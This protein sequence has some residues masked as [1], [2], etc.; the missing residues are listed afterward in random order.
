[1]SVFDS[2]DVIISNLNTPSQGNET[3]IT[4]KCLKCP[5]KNE[6]KQVSSKMCPQTSVLKD[7]SSNKCPQRCVLK[8]VSS[9]MCPLKVIK[10]VTFM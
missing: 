5:Q 1:M 8:E 4:F 2:H 10:S 6:F 9:K 7:V 3:D